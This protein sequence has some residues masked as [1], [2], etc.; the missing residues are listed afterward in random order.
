MTE[1]CSDG[2]KGVLNNSLLKQDSVL[3]SGSGRNSFAYETMKSKSV[4]VQLALQYLLA[5]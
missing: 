3:I 4:K 2:K 1:A 5:N